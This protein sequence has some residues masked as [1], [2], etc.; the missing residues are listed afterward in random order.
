MYTNEKLI[1]N[2][3]STATCDVDKDVEKFWMKVNKATSITDSDQKAVADEANQKCEAISD[4]TLHQD[5]ESA[6][7]PFSSSSLYL[8]SNSKTDVLQ[9]EKQRLILRSAALPRELYLNSAR[10]NNSALP[11]NQT[12]LSSSDD[13]KCF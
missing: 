10:K 2:D 9:Q 7:M 5:I 8:N 13:G 11:E 6:K 4:K 3:A 1:K 12:L